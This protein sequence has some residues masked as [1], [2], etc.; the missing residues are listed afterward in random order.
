VVL[1]VVMYNSN[2]DCDMRLL[3]SMFDA[4]FFQGVLIIL[5]LVICERNNYDVMQ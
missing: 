3:K 5:R 2:N 4:I 1:R